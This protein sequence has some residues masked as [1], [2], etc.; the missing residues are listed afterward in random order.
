MTK[1]SQVQAPHQFGPRWSKLVGFVLVKVLW[2]VRVSGA[3]NIP[4]SGPVIVAGNHSALLDGPLLLGITPRPAHFLVKGS[5]FKGVL[6]PILIAGGHIAVRP[7]QGRETLTRA[8]AVLDR[9]GAIGIFPEGTRGTGQVAAIHP[10][11]AWLAC[12]SQAPVVPVAIVGTRHSGQSVT[13]LP[14]PWS[15]ITVQYGAPI[16]PE[17]GEHTAR[18]DIAALAERVRVELAKAVA[19]AA[20][21]SGTALPNDAP[22]NTAP[23]H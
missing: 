6:K 19:D 16:Y 23:E 10:G 11:V 13:A 15:T 7:G 14:R 9:G 3:Q 22:R 12:H 1:S 18:R 5:L 21:A 2:R 8:K 20:R 4:T 17:P